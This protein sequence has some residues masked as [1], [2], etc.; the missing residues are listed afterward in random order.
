MLAQLRAQD[1]TQP[2]LASLILTITIQML[3]HRTGTLKNIPVRVIRVFGI[4][5]ICMAMA[6]T[7]PSNADIFDA[8]VVLESTRKFGH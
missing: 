4:T 2:T 3:L 6:D 8:V 5:D 1:R 7:A